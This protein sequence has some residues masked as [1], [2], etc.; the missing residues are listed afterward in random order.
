[1]ATIKITVEHEDINQDKINQMLDLIGFSLGKHFPGDSAELD[2]GRIKQGIMYI[3]LTTVD[4]SAWGM[5][6]VEWCAT[7]E[8]AVDDRLGMSIEADLRK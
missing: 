1:M 5:T 4:R 7:L 6:M 8:D 2:L 3:N